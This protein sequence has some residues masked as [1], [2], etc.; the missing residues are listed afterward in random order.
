MKYVCLQTCQ[1]KVYEKTTLVKRGAVV[2]VPDDPGQRFRCLEDPVVEYQIDF[3][4]ASEQ[5]LKNAKW[6]F[7]DAKKAIGEAYGVELTRED[8]DKKSDIIAQILDAKYR[9]IN[10]TVLEKPLP[11][12]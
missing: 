9:A 10:P 5:E 11:Q 12:E 3:L 4:K 1:I 6:K 2:D 8:G 7:A